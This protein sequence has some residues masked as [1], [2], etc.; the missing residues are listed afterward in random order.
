MLFRSESFVG[1]FFDLVW[2]DASVFIAMILV[3]LLR[4]EGLFQQRAVR[5]G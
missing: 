4:P 1:G 2:Q 3:L 5:V